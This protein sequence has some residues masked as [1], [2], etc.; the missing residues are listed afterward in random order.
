MS[1]REGN[2]QQDATATED[3]EQG[4]L[5]EVLAEIADLLSSEDEFNAPEEK[6]DK[7]SLATFRFSLLAFDL[8]EQKRRL[9]AAE[10]KCLLHS[11]K[12]SEEKTPTQDNLAVYV[13]LRDPSWVPIFPGLADRCAKNM[14]L[15]LKSEVPGLKEFER[16]AKAK[17][18]LPLTGLVKGPTE[19]KPDSVQAVP[20]QLLNH[21]GYPRR[22]AKGPPRFAQTLGTLP[23]MVPVEV[24]IVN[25][26]TFS[27]LPPPG[28]C[29]EDDDDE[30]DMGNFLEPLDMDEDEEG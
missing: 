24:P 20:V 7:T 18:S 13:F 23:E 10:G 25:F 8:L 29:L 5:N 14:L 21:P 2:V 11:S 22:S 4:L 3:F 6:E 19:K 30:D 28:L 15:N 9:T 12:V 27:V 1:L 16:K 17:P 26:R